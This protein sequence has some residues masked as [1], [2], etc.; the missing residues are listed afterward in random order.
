MLKEELATNIKEK[1][2]DYKSSG[3]DEE[4]AFKEAVIIP[5]TNYPRKSGSNPLLRTGGRFSRPGTGER[6]P[7]PATIIPVT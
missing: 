1:I 7:C 3:K 6:S 4:Q 5:D 2:V